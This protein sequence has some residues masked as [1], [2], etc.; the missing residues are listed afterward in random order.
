MI[1]LENYVKLSLDQ[2]NHIFNLFC[3]IEGFVNVS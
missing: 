2:E 1:L 3:H